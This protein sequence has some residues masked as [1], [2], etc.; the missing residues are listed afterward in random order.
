MFEFFVSLHNQQSKNKIHSK[1][2]LKN[3]LSCL[4]AIILHNYFPLTTLSTLRTYV[5]TILQYSNEFLEMQHSGQHI[6]SL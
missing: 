5:K 2:F 4:R 1:A 3:S 6:V